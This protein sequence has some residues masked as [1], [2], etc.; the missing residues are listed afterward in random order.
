MANPQPLDGESEEVEW[1]KKQFD[2][3]QNIP[4]G[5]AIKIQASL[6]ALSG[7]RIGWDGLLSVPCPPAA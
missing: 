3:T 1:L 5:T 4:K 2:P 6:P 7:E